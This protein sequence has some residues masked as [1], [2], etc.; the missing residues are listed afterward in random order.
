MGEEFWTERGVRQGCPMSPILFNILMSDI[1]EEM[2]KISWEGIKLGERKI[3]SL[4]YADDVVLIAEKEE[5]MKKWGKYVEGKNME[6][7]VEETKLMRF[8]RG[9]E[10]NGKNRL[11]IHVTQL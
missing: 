4:A 3:Y 6:V 9:G 10:V 11:E 5:E 7:N 8:R 1:E 2:G